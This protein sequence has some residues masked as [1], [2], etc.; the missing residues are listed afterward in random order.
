QSPII[1]TNWRGWRISIDQRLLQVLS[2]TTVLNRPKTI[3]KQ[4]LP[5][6]VLLRYINQSCFKNVNKDAGLTLNS[7]PHNLTISLFISTLSVL[8]HEDRFEEEMPPV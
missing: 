5:N 4:R 8:V 1:L 2:S 3:G 7:T 6:Q